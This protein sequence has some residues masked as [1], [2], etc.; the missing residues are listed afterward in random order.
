MTAF[1]LIITASYLLA[2]LLYLADR[3]RND[4]RDQH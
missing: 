4:R 1:F 3:K 2:D